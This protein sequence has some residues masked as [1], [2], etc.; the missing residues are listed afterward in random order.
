MNELPIYADIIIRKGEVFT[1]PYVLVEELYDEETGE[2]TTTPWDTADSTARFV[3]TP[4]GEAGA[5]LPPVIELTEEAS[6]EGQV[7]VGLTGLAGIQTSV[8]VWLTSLKTIDLDWSGL[9]IYTSWVNDVV[10]GQGT[11]RLQR[12]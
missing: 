2:T 6:S 1:L 5:L 3:V 7:V 8:F 11:A 9:A 4:L 10:V 12:T